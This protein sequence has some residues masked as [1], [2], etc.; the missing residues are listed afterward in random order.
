LPFIQMNPSRWS[1]GKADIAHS[2]AYGR[3]RGEVSRKYAAS[4]VSLIW[5]GG[6]YKTMGL[7]EKTAAGLGA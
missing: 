7:M 1:K 5:Q 3:G 6:D 4:M 2:W